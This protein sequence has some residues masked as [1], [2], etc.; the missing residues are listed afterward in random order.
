MPLE[1]PAVTCASCKKMHPTAGKYLTVTATVTE[2]VDQ[3]AN[4]R[5]RTKVPE[6][7]S[8]TD[9]AV[10]DNNCLSNLLSLKGCSE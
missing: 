8:V 7:V 1:T 5:Y 3:T 4:A 6:S 10:C 9:V 2:H